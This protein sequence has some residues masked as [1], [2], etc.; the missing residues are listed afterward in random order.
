MTIQAKT[1]KTKYEGKNKALIPAYFVSYANTFKN[2][3]C[4]FFAVEPNANRIF[5]KYISDDYIREFQKKGDHKCYIYHF[6]A[7]EIVTQENVRETIGRWKQ[8][9]NDKLTSFS[10][11]KKNSEAI[12]S[13]NRIAFQIINDNFIHL[14]DSFIERKEINQLYQW[15]KEDLK[16][17]EPNIKLLVGNAGMGK[18][19]VV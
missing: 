11:I 9:F 18:S 8:L 3:V 6:L 17:Q 13:E 19:V 14:K 12:I 4:L 10:Q 5:W 7:D 2:K 15:V 16:E 1:Y